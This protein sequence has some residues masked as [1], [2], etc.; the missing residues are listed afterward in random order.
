MHF[1]FFNLFFLKK[2]LKNQNSLYNSQI[3]AQCNE[4]C[5]CSERVPRMLRCVC[6]VFVHQWLWRFISQTCQ[7]H[8]KVFFGPQNV[9][10]LLLV[11]TRINFQQLQAGRYYIQTQILE[12]SGKKNKR[13]PTWS[14]QSDVNSCWVLGFWHFPPVSPEPSSL[15]CIFSL[16]PADIWNDNFWYSCKYVSIGR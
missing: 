16:T 12:F 1:Y 9:T 5:R 4:Q 8:A 3:L 14:P 15:T 6:G 13:S 11:L 10:V 2:K 7:M